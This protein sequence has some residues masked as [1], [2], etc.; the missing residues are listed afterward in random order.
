MLYALFILYCF[1]S[2]FLLG[3]FLLDK[4]SIWWLLALALVAFNGFMAFILF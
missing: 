3:S 2:G 4:A 1:I